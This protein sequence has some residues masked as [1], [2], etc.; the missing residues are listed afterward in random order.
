MVWAWVTVTGRPAHVRE[1]HAG[2]SSIEVAWM[3]AEAFRSYEQTANAAERR[4]PAFA[5]ELPHYAAT[6]LTDARPNRLYQGTQATCY[7]PDAQ[8]IHGIDEGVGLV[9]MHGTTRVLA[10]TIAAWC[11]LE[12]RRR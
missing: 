4:H 6:G 9:C 8:N 1:K 11:G 12:K 7:G 3:V 5:A 10:L 2:V